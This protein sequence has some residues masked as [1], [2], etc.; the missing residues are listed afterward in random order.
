MSR[1]VH[2]WLRQSRTV[3][4]TPLDSAF[5][6]DLGH[7]DHD[8]RDCKKLMRHP[9]SLESLQGWETTCLFLTWQILPGLPGWEMTFP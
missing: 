9:S 1:A 3:P 7:G 2:I 6:D 8:D 5:L 4:P